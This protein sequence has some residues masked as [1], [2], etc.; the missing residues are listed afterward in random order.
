MDKGTHFYRCDFQVHTP[1]DRQWHGDRPISE[2]DRRSYAVDF[3]AACR[4]KRLD[5][6]AIT[7]HHDMAFIPYIREAAAN[8]LDAEGN[9]LPEEQRIQIFPG[10]ELTL[11]IPCQALLIFGADF[12]DDMFGLA[13]T[14]LTI[15]PAN[16]SEPQCHE[17]ERLARIT[18][19]QELQQELDKHEYLKGN[20]ILLPNVSEGGASTLLRS[21]HSGHYKNMPCVG[22]YLDGNISQLG[23]GNIRILS[24]RDIEYGNKSVALFQTSDNRSRD[25]AQLGTEATWVKWA[26]PTA[27]ALRQACLAYESRISQDTP[28]VP[29]VYITS[30]SVSNSTFMGPINIEFSSQFNSII[31]GRGTG[32]STILEYLRWGLCDEVPS[33]IDYEDLPSYEAKRDS[34]IRQTLTALNANVQVNFI[35][36]GVP[37]SVRRDSTNGE[38]TLKIAGGD[39]D[40]CTEQDVR[41]LLPIQAYS[42]KQLSNVAIRIEELTRFIRSP[43]RQ[44]LKNANIQLEQTAL[45]MRSVYSSL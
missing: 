16:A 24:G 23:E 17:I 36:N 45:Q 21:G 40:T 44:Q 1:R 28:L 29:S 5:A 15:T 26:V 12:P 31:G 25:F 34:L 11:G 14:S 32:K 33:S 38:L 37:H 2:E 9:P 13:T 6:V 18:T 43:I 30:L 19:L 27:E 22:G 20:Y 41:N 8:E 35:V 39:F 42:Q 4:A 3:I 7:D 10:M